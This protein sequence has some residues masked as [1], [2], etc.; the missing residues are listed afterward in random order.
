MQSH[1]SPERIPWRRLL[2]GL[3]ALGVVIAAGAFVLLKAEIGGVRGTTIPVHAVFSDARDIMPNS[4]VWLN[5]ELVGTVRTIGF[6]APEAG[7]SNR[8]Y[9]TMDVLER[10]RPFI[11]RD[12]IVQVRRGESFLGAPVLYIAGGSPGVPAV[13]AGDTL[14]TTRW[15][16]QDQLAAGIR[17]GVSDLQTVMSNVRVTARAIREAQGSIAALTGTD[18][19]TEPSEISIVLASWDSLNDQ[20]EALRTMVADTALRAGIDRLMLQLDS[21]NRA[22]REGSARLMLSD[23]TLRRSAG[24]LASELTV[25]REALGQRLAV[26]KG[27]F[28]ED[29]TDLSNLPPSARADIT[30]FH[31][32][33][34]ALIQDIKKRPWKYVGF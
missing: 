10:V 31:A 16:N 24:S 28:Q 19:S 4:E 14:G 27:A 12:A 17:G 21:L 1:H 26:A 22:S 33:L 2:K 15:L 20:A 29:S 13:N 7:E 32:A 23:T 30:R 5:G 11:R 25:V 9:M 3:V 18:G 34:D 8:L 6:L